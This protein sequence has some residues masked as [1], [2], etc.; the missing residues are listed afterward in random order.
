MPKLTKVIAG[1]ALSTALTG[2]ALAATA[3]VANATIAPTQWGWGGFSNSCCDDSTDWDNITW[4]IF[5]AGKHGAAHHGFGLF[6]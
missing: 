1:L 2:G 5:V 4:N 6:H 3:S